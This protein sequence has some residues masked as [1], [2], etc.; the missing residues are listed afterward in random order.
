MWYKYAVDA[1]QTLIG[2]KIEWVDNFK[3]TFG[4]FDPY[5]GNAPDMTTL[6]QWINY[7]LPNKLSQYTSQKNVD[8]TNS[9]RYI[10]DIREFLKFLENYENYHLGKDRYF[11]DMSG[12]WKGHALAVHAIESL[13][14]DP[15]YITYESTSAG[16]TSFVE[17]FTKQGYGV[18]RMIEQSGL[19][20]SPQFYYTVIHNIE[21]QA[22]L[23]TKNKQAFV[24]YIIAKYP[25]MRLYLN[26]PQTNREL[27]E[28]IRTGDI[29][30][31]ATRDLLKQSVPIY[32][33]KTI[34]TEEADETYEG[35][36]ST[37]NKAFR[38]YTAGAAID[39]GT[40]TAEQEKYFAAAAENPSIST[41][42]CY[43]LGYWLGDKTKIDI[44]QK[45]E[46]GK[47][48]CR[49]EAL[50]Q[51]AEKLI[52]EDLSGLSPQEVADFR[53]TKTAQLLVKNKR[54][55]GEKYKKVVQAGLLPEK[56]TVEFYQANPD[57]IQ[58]AKFIG[59]I[60]APSVKLLQQQGDVYQEQLKNNT[61]LK[62]R[63][64]VMDNKIKAFKLSSDP[65]MMKELL[66]VGSQMGIPEQKLMEIAPSVTVYKFRTWALRQAFGNDTVIGPD[67]DID[68]KWSG[69][70]VTSYDNYDGTTGPAIFI[71]TDA[72]KYLEYIASLA[73]NIDL[74]EEEFT[75]AVDR[76]ELVHLARF[77]GYG[78]AWRNTTSLNKDKAAKYVTDPDEISAMMF[79][80]VPHMK[81]LFM[82]KLEELSHTEIVQR[83][84]RNQFIED[85]ENDPALTAVL[86]LIIPQQIEDEAA[87]NEKYFQHTENPMDEVEKTKRR[88]REKI[89]E[90]F[91]SVIATARRREILELLKRRNE[92]RD[93][94]E[95]LQNVEPNK[96][97]FF[98]GLLGKED[99]AN[100]DKI[101]ELETEITKVESEFARL[102]KGGIPLTHLEP[103]GDLLDAGYMED[104]LYRLIEAITTGQHP[105]GKA[106]QE[107]LDEMKS[108]IIPKKSFNKD[109]IEEESSRPLNSRDIRQHARFLV[110]NAP[111]GTMGYGPV[112][113]PGT[114]MGAL[115]FLPE[116]APKQD[117]E[118]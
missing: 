89:G 43:S 17:K 47:L 5:S 96:W 88:Q 59:H 19:H 49:P 40:T 53:E 90:Y 98:T 45:T 57:A 10:A 54:F 92:L 37:T 83:A 58:G 97:S 66:A 15:G 102:K 76:H 16:N 24:D 13:G 36:F 101:E 117:Q 118:V 1:Y 80:N 42:A 25:L 100:A 67:M 85:V 73:E 112:M 111:G 51:L 68:E 60:S 33:R 22:G 116:D 113:F 114:N 29:K 21:S 4:K 32:L 79:G 86:G 84:I 91:D 72:K 12:I 78:K 65:S 64:A 75:S 107:Q 6:A 7:N 3:N 34:E 20:F 95:T 93:E 35:T 38:E 77:T 2:K 99:T 74:A 28:L 30:N 44:I 109:D 39:S 103:F 11:S 115:P 41:Y 70:F 23:D 61:T 106:N 27:L 87:N 46:A 110:D 63:K 104:W 81:Q 69:M 18:I 56:E 108:N 94:M 50:I 48:K 82:K 71:K 8:E 52:G 105:I 26:T 62:M 9:E 14:G 55:M 31:P